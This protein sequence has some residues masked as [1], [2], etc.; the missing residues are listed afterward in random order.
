MNPRPRKFQRRRN[1]TVVEI[2]RKALMSRSF[3]AW[4][5]AAEFGGGR[6]NFPQG[7]DVAKLLGWKRRQNSEASGIFHKPLMS[8]D[9][10]DGFAR[11]QRDLPRHVR[12]LGSG[13]GI[14]ARLKFCAWA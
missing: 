9:F 6:L 14:R 4:E 10:S 13:G 8:R 12:G 11:L 2:F 1:S 5:A 3:S 7:L